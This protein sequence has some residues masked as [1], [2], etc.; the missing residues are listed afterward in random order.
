MTSCREHACLSLHTLPP[1]GSTVTT[2]TRTQW[3]ARAARGGPGPLSASR[4][5]GIALHWPAMSRPVRG[6]KAVAAALRNWQSYHMNTQGWSDIG[7]QL[8][9]D[10]D[11]NRYELRGMRTQSG[12]NGN[13]TL[14]QQFGAVLLVLA[15]GEHPTEAMVRE[16]HTIIAEHRGH[17][18]SSRRIVGH[19][20]IRPEGSQCP[21]PITQDLI[22]RGA[23]EPDASTTTEEDDMSAEDVWN[24]PLPTPGG[25]KQ[26]AKWVLTQ[27]HNRAGGA[28]NAATAC[29][30]AV[31]DL[32]ALVGDTSISEKDKREL[33]DRIAKR[34]AEA[35][36]RLDAESVAEQLEVGVK[37]EES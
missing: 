10:Q 21:G 2:Y 35:V 12:A 33:A 11:G 26:R 20:Q 32:A 28:R 27:A 7:Y 30:Q 6:F 17:F 31:N 19:G 22:N 25:G 29:L 16:V 37:G 36:E 3:G 8:A 9:V 15:P 24:H 34:T 5:I 23:F 1:E 14:N 13:T 18:P 4:V